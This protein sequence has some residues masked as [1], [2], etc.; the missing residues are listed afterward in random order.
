M[1]F[2][3]GEKTFNESYKKILKAVL[4]LKYPDYGYER[5]LQFEIKD[6]ICIFKYNDIIEYVGRNAENY[7]SY[8]Q[9][10]GYDA[11]GKECKWGI[12]NKFSIL[13]TPITL[14]EVVRI[15]AYQKLSKNNNFDG[16]ALFIPFDSDYEV[17]VGELIIEWNLKN[18]LHEQSQEAIDKIAKL[19]D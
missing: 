17:H 3:G 1:A 11:M 18:Y 14:A 13:G 5:A 15:V 7:R 4:K 19:L 6:P 10:Y 12:L 8:K 2:I 9:G 16:K